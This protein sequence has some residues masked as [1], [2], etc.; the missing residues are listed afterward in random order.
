MM[1]EP[2]PVPRAAL[3]TGA[4]HRIGRA[5]AQDLAAHGFAVALHAN[6]SAA[7]ARALAAEIAAAGGRAAAVI[8]DLAEAERLPG[9]LADAEALVGPLGVL[10]NCAALFED[11]GAAVDAAAME[12][13]F[14]VNTLAPAVLAAAFAARLPEGADGVVV[15]ILDQRVL[16]LTPDH[17]AYGVSKSALW[18]ATRMLADRLAPR[19]RVLGIGPG[20]VLPH[21]GLTPEAFAREVD[22]TPLRHAPR[23]ADFGRTIR[24][25][26]ETPSLTGQ[27]LALDSGQH[28]R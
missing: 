13:H 11:D 5:I 6:R 19:V 22:A 21:E 20:P 25:F 4:A 1:R 7:A 16:R 3:V 10:V 26:V 14:R 17:F 24:Y 12:R 15:N 23:L 28:L 9:L 27:M 18:A 2:Q 8:A